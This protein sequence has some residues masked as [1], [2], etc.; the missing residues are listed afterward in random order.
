MKIFTISRAARGLPAALAAVLFLGAP[1][2]HFDIEAADGG[3]IIQAQTRGMERR[4]DRRDAVQEGHDAVQDNRQDRRGD[5][6][7]CRQDEGVVGHGKRDCKQDER[8]DRVNN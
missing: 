3:L 4:D 1:S 7:D 2:P 5:R 6:Q 8:Q